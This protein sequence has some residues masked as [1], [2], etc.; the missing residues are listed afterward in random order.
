MEASLRKLLWEISYTEEHPLTRI[1][2]MDAYDLRVELEGR[3]KE[4]K[5]LIVLD[6][7]W[8]QDV[9]IHMIKQFKSSGKLD[10]HHNSPKNQVA[11][12]ARPTRHL[13]LRPLSNTHA[14][15][16]FCR[17]AF[18]NNVCPMELEK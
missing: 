4:R 11:A 10:H 5:C 7:H 15:N 3:L 17:I 16:P 2:K 13:D 14:F 6:D 18:Q 1:D 9:Y 12:L 8:N